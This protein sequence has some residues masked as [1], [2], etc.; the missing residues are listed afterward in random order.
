MLT[1]YRDNGNHV[2]Q[3]RHAVLCRQVDQIVMQ[4]QLVKAGARCQVQQVKGGAGDKGQ[5]S[6]G[7]GFPRGGLGG[8]GG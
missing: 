7:A 1:T 8:G 3:H 4:H 6:A 2:V 5:A